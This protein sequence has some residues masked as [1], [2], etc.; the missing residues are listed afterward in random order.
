MSKPNVATSTSL[1]QND[2]FQPVNWASIVRRN[3][4]SLQSELQERISEWRSQLKG[5]IN[6]NSP[7]GPSID[8]LYVGGIARDPIA[9]LKKG[10]RK[11]LPHLA[12]LNICFIGNVTEILNH[13]PLPPRFIATIKL[14][15]FSILKYFVPDKS[16]VDSD[17]KE[18]LIR[19]AKRC[20]FMS[21]KTRSPA[22]TEW[23]QGYL[24]HLV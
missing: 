4:S 10:L 13:K 14:L 6:P 5:F 21:S 20:E 23:Y 9:E 22:C 2:I 8:A 7:T 17:A 18:V 16:K 3:I 19:C 12:V 1:T 15:G 24:K 11:C